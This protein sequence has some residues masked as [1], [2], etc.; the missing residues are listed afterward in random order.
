MTKQI[1]AYLQLIEKLCGDSGTDKEALARELLTRIQFYQ[2][3]RLIHL[4]VT[5]SFGV[6]FLI[7]LVLL[8]VNVY[9][10]SLSVLLFVLLVPYIMH[11]YFLEN[12]VQKLYKFYYS[13]TEKNNLS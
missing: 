4:I 13:L 7:S 1:K 3:E 12:S 8:T 5:M 10:A 11:Y 2:H 9:F 6:F